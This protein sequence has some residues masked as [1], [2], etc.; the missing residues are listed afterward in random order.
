M[1]YII[2]LNKTT[3]NMRQILFSIMMFGPISI[4]KINK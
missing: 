3:S 4:N 1:V 2:I